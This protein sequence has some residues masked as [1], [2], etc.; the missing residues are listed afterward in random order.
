MDD[1]LAPW[2]FNHGC[3]TITARNGSDSK[4]GVAAGGQVAGF[5]N[6]VEIY[7]VADGSWRYGIELMY[8]YRV[9]I[10]V[11]RVR[12]E[13]LLLLYPTT[14]ESTNPFFNLN[15]HLTLA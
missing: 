6:T 15:C 11:N 4:E 2:R 8:H 13:I 14:S 5:A 10:Q 9:T 1:F 12:F 3:G 7:S